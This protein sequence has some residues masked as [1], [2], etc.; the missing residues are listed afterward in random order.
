MC[1]AENIRTLKTYGFFNTR[2][3]TMPSCLTRYPFQYSNMGFCTSTFPYNLHATSAPDQKVGEANSTLLIL[4]V[5][6]KNVLL[7]R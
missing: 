6:E 5:S 3:K 7:N 1:E 4:V 2:I